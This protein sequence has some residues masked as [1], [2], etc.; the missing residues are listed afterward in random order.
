MRITVLFLGLCLLLLA[1]GNPRKGA[2]SPDARSALDKLADQNL[3]PKKKYLILA[4]RYVQLLDETAAFSTNAQALA[5]L[6]K[7][8]SDNQ[9]AL[10]R[11]YGQFDGWQRNTNEQDLMLFLMELNEEDFAPKLRRLER[12]LRARLN[13]PAERQVFDQ[14]MGYLKMWR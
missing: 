1:C 8:N 2:L 10:S 5:H 11:L 3:E 7:F 12:D 9:N 6:E 13:G 4:R 14:T